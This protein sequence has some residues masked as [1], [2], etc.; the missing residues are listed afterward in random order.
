MFYFVCAAAVAYILDGLGAVFYCCHYL[1]E[2][3]DRGTRDFLVAEFCGIREA[4][5]LG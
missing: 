2:M 5:A 4:L 1:V 3:G